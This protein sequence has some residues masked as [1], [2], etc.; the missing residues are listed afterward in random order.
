M[1]EQ[2]NVMNRRNS[3]KSEWNILR[4]V[5]KMLVDAHVLNT[6]TTTPILDFKSPNELKVIK[7]NLPSPTIR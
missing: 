2:E 3:F 5:H 7:F 1:S 4:D 6:P